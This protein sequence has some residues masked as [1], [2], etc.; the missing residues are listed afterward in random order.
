MIDHDRLFKELISTFFVDFLDLFV[1]E[2]LEYL[3]VNS[4]EFLDKEVF[5]DVTAGDHHEV[6]LVVKGKFQGQSACFLIHVEY[7]ASKKGNFPER[8][9]T[10]FCRLRE[11]YGLPVYPIVLFSYDKPLVAEPTR[12]EVR[13]P[14]RLILQ[15]DYTGIQLNRL[16]WREFLVRKNPLASALMAKMKI[17]VADR[18]RVKVECLRLLATLQLDRAKMQM[19]SGFIDAYLNLKGNELT[20]FECEMQ[21]IE[22][23]ERQEIMEIMTS[24]KEEGLQQGLQQGLQEGKKEGETTLLL[25]L[26]QKRMGM[27][28]EAITHQIKDLSLAQL[29]SLAVALLDFHTEADLKAWFDANVT[30]LEGT[31]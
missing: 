20:E 29:E 9:F 8:M 24:W 1:P 31:N 13:F 11:K 16:N 26:L 3:D 21:G 10:Y 28:S 2:T 30:S 7:Q 6:D 27:V 19:I 4:L 12:F 25:L 14:D 18:P 15:F 17:A 23:G 5:T 22:P